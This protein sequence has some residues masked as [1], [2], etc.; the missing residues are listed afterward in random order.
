MLTKV[1]DYAFSAITDFVKSRFVKHTKFDLVYINLWAD[2]FTTPSVVGSNFST[3]L[4]K[5]IFPDTKKCVSCKAYVGNISE[6]RLDLDYYNNIYMLRSA[7]KANNI[8][9]RTNRFYP[10]RYIPSLFGTELINAISSKKY[11]C[12]T[13]T[14]LPKTPKPFKY[15]RF[16]SKSPEEPFY[17]VHFAENK[18]DLYTDNVFVSKSVRAEILFQNNTN[19]L[20]DEKSLVINPYYGEVICADNVINIFANSKLYKLFEK[21]V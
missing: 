8:F 4:H 10:D 20:R 6:E 16:S 9:I 19:S 21:G 15:R 14:I 5:V 3:C 17:I 7:I 13:Y 12:R 18:R 1:T 2:E 11:Y